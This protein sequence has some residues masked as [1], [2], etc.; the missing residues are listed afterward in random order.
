VRTVPTAYDASITCAQAALDKLHALQLQAM[1]NGDLATMNALQGDSNA[2]TLKLTQLRALAVADDDA[3][4]AALN[5][6]LD[7]VTKS[8]TDEMS[9]LGSLATVLNNILAVSKLLDSIIAAIP[10]V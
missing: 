2:M 7:A 10:K 4:I 3:Q 8:I 6:K 5:A 9:S 1:S